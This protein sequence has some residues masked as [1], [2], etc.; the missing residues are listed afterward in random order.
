MSIPLQLVEVEAN[1]FHILVN[2]KCRGECL[3]LL[4]DTGASRSVMDL[5]SPISVYG[6]TISESETPKIQ[7]INKQIE[8]K[9]IIRLEDIDFDGVQDI[10][11]DFYLI[12]LEDVNSL[13][14]DQLGYRLDGILGGDFLFG[15]SAV[16]DYRNQKLLIFKP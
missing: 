8:L 10:R 9:G 13:Y 5:N 3:K 2:A 11:H 1:S 4:V 6:K 7:M 14:L 16:V 12:D 15:K